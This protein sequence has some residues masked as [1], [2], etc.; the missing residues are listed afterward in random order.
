MK[1]EMREL[2]AMS[3]EQLIAKF[4]PDILTTRDSANRYFEDQKN[5]SWEKQFKDRPYNSYGQLSGE[6][7]L[8]YPGLQHIYAHC[9]DEEIV[10][11]PTADYVRNV[12]LAGVDHVHFEFNGS[13]DSGNSSIGDAYSSADE[14]TTVVLSDEA[15]NWLQE[16]VEPM[17]SDVGDWWNNEGG[18]GN[19]VF[20]VQS[21]RLCVQV[22]FNTEEA[23]DVDVKTKFKDSPPELKEL[24]TKNGVT[25]MAWSGESGCNIELLALDR[26]GRVKAEWDNKGADDPAWVKALIQEIEA[27]IEYATHS[28]EVNFNEKLQ[29]KLDGSCSYNKAVTGD[30][31]T[32]FFSIY[33]EEECN[34]ADDDRLCE[35]AN[36]VTGDDSV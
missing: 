7:L 35:I 12:L 24:I 25:S 15:T 9:S 17:L 3:E 14:D 33:A 10:L 20:G 29:Y 21:G 23:V 6:V 27:S 13:G 32:E 2:N 36:E 22:A 28:G 31:K 1:I 30:W 5:P 4:G 8:K 16:V 18:S 34:E 26:S 11:H 19:A